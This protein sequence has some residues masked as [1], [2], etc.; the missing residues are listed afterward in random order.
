[1]K[2]YMHTRPK[3]CAFTLLEMS[4]V[5]LIIGIMV[6][7]ILPA[8]TQQQAIE[9]AQEL[10]QKLDAIEAAIAAFRRED[11]RLPCPAQQTLALNTANFGVEAD[12]P[13]TC[14]G[15]TPAATDASDAA[16]DVVV[17]VVPVRTLGLSDD[18]AY[19][20]WGRAFTYAIDARMTGNGAYTTY[21]IG[22]ATIGNL[23]VQTRDAVADTLSDI[24]TNAILV[25]MT[26]GPN[27]HG[28]YLPSGGRYSSGSTNA[29][30]QE[31]CN[32][33]LT[34]AVD[35]GQEDESFVTALQSSGLGGGVDNYDDT[36]RYYLR[37]SFVASGDF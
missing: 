23:T 34:A 1:M 14:T 28:A 25:V 29:D 24:T 36:L 2:H 4:I 19:D 10:E 22:D 11:N 7:S 31:N 17:G 27:G 35:T 33:T 15:S 12:T 32:C 21:P 5:I 3:K 30:E 13:G 26:H 8:I 18:M 20:P 37:N 9:N 16:G 6:A